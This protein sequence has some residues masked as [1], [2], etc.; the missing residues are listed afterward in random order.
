L[1]ILLLFLYSALPRKNVTLNQ[2]E[3]KKG[4]GFAVKDAEDNSS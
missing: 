4:S 3:E 1:L 2:E